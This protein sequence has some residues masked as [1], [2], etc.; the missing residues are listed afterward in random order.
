V[1]PLA[2]RFDN[3]H[4]RS[5]ANS[6]PRR[7]LG[8]GAQCDRRLSEQAV[9]VAPAD[10]QNRPLRLGWRRRIVVAPAAGKEDDGRDDYGQVAGFAVPFVT[11]VEIV[12]HQAPPS[13]VRWNTLSYCVLPR[14][15]ECES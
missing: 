7:S 3:A 5:V 12:L 9:L 8:L 2:S 11:F 10:E 4:Q 1:N 15:Y 14:L 13:P 6:V